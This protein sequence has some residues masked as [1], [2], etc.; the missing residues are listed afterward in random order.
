MKLLEKKVINERAS[1]ER[2]QVIDS[3]I[4]FAT[5]VD[6]LRDEYLSLQ[7][8]RED[9]IASSQDLLRDSIKELK[10]ERDNLDFEVKEQVKRLVKLREPLDAEWEELK[11]QQSD[12][13][14]LKLD[15]ETYFQSLIKERGELHLEK[16]VMDSLKEAAE[17]NEIRTL[18]ILRQI[19]DER[20]ET[21]RILIESRNIKENKES[22]LFLKE[23]LL[24][25]KEQRLIKLEKELRKERLDINKEIQALSI[26]KQRRQ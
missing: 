13:L 9:Y 25:D 22:S 2:K 6:K 4:I 14:Q 15:S 21:K 26:K 12:V 17:D 18:K 1:I 11:H 16:E 19:E 24:N 3:G 7:K 10:T 20:K 5:K 23:T 8:Q